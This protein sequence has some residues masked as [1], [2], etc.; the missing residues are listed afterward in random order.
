MVFLE[1]TYGDRNHRPF[2]ETVEEF[3]RVVKEAASTNEK[4]LV[5]T[6]AVGRAQ[7]LIGL[8]GW[9]FRTKKVAPFP[10]FLD[11]PMAFRRRISTRTIVNCSTTP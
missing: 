11:S 1:S 2:M 7:L 8:L 9:M 10:I 4:M 3:V 6:F 5:P